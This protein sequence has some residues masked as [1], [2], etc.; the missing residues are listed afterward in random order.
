MPDSQ[1]TPHALFLDFY[2][3]TAEVKSSNSDLLESLRFDFS[4]FIVEAVSKPL[5]TID[6][7][8]EPPP[9]HSIPELIESM[10]SPEFVCFDQGSVRYVNYFGRALVR[11]DY[12]T[13]SAQMY[14]LEREYLY[15]KLYLLLLSRTGEILDKRGLHRVHGLGVT[16]NN[17]AALFLMPSGGGKS[18]LALSLLAHPEIKLL[19]ED[20]PLVDAQGLVHPFPLRLGISKKQIPQG[21]P[22]HL[23]REFH[24]E[25]WG[26]K[27]LLH[28]DYFKGKVETASKP[29]RYIFSGK[30]INSDSPRIERVG[31][32]SAFITLMRDCV[33]GLGLPQIV[34]FFL[35]S[36]PLDLLKKIGIA[37]RRVFTIVRLVASS[38]PYRVLLSRDLS[39]NRELILK[40]F[41]EDSS[42]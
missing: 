26:T 36:N 2:G 21:A 6:A 13:E 12:A 28:I 23:V 10:R 15:E 5:V 19:S 22:L 18:T 38:A 3:A 24:R 7:T 27:Y 16:Y 8:I 29:L 37:L 31:R 25:R 4:S 11:F 20:T 9:W 35:T 17:K 41:R 33:F 34:E 39:A 30:W 1:H 32:I 14:S 40:F 42:R